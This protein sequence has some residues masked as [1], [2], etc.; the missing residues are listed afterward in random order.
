LVSVM[1]SSDMNF[2]PISYEVRGFRQLF[3]K[4]LNRHF[5]RYQGKTCPLVYLGC[6]FVSVK[7]IDAFLSA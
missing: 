6:I 5:C 4:S 2:P 3:F 1:I 7:I